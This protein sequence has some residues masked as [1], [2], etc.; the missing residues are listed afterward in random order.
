MTHKLKTWPEAFEAVLSGQKT[1]EMRVN[2]RDFQSG[3]SLLLVEWDP[4]TEAFSGRYAICQVTYITPGGAFGVLPQNLVVMSIHVV[5]SSK[6][7]TINRETMEVMLG[8]STH[9]D[10][11][12]TKQ[13][14]APVPILNIDCNVDEGHI[15]C[16]TVHSR[17]L[18][19]D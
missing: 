15:D 10:F 17:A 9:E 16:G 5:N 18:K 11:G 8:V 12:E 13:E 4:K 7:C 1:H 14:I 3:D 2:D 6:T 19:Q